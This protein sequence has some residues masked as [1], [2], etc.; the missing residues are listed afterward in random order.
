MELVT[1]KLTDGRIFRGTPEVITQLRRLTT[2][3]MDGKLPSDVGGELV[4]KEI[5]DATDAGRLTI[6]LPETN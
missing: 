4:D 5:A 2:A 3:V 1:W 6:T